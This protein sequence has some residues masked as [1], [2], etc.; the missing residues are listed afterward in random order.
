LQKQHMPNIFHIPIG[1]DSPRT[2]SGVYRRAVRRTRFLAETD[3]DARIAMAL[4]KTDPPK[5]PG[6]VAPHPLFCTASLHRL[7]SG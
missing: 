6:A 1:P 2:S 7:S 4:R 3:A 5:T